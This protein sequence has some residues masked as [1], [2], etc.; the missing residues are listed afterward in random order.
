MELWTMNSISTMCSWNYTLLQYI[1]F[2][3][4]SIFPLFLPLPLRLFLL[5]L[6]LFLLPL[7]LFLLLLHLFLLSF[8]LF[9]LPLHL[10]LLPLSLL[11]YPPPFPPFL[12]S[13][14]IPLLLLFRLLLLYLFQ[15]QI[16][17]M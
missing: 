12:T 7:H 10:F 8:H 13:I 16:T 17:F 1:C 2:Y 6:H 14:N 11:L 3:F 5:P 4:T 15:K 9:L